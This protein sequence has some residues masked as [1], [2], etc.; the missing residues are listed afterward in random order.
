M[1]KYSFAK[2]EELKGLKKKE[3]QRKT[4]TKKRAI[5]I[6]FTAK[7][8]LKKKKEIRNE[9]LKKIIPTIT[10]LKEKKF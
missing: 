9:M 3:N 5:D 1:R 4:K 7:L 8:N 2:L 10:K 6:P